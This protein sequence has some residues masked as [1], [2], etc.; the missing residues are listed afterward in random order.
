[1]DTAVE[2]YAANQNEYA[3]EEDAGSKGRAVE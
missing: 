1:M 3:A 2:I